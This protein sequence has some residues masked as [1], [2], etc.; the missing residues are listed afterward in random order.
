ME[1][2]GICIRGCTLI[3]LLICLMAGYCWAEENTTLTFTG[4]V[5]DEEGQAIE[6]VKVTFYDF[7]APDTD[8]MY[9]WA[10]LEQKEAMTKEDG[11]F[12]F[13]STAQESSSYRLGFIVAEKEGYAIGWANWR[14]R[15]GD[16]G[17]IELKKPMILGGKVIDESGIPVVDAEVGIIMLAENLREER[18][19]LGIEPLN[20]FKTMTDGEG[21]FSFENIPEGIM[22]EFMVRKNGKGTVSTLDIETIQQQRLNFQAGQDDIEIHIAD[23]S[24]IEGTVVRQDNKEP[25][26]GIELMLREEQGIPFLGSEAVTT[27]D[28]GTFR[29]EALAG[30]DYVL[31]TIPEQESEFVAKTLSVSIGDGERK[32]VI[33]ELSEGAELQVIV[34]ETE[35]GDAVENARVFVIN[36]ETG[37]S[38]QGQTD[39]NGIAKI[40]MPNGE[41]QINHI[42][43]EGFSSDRSQETFT[44]VS[45]ETKRIE[46]KLKGQPKITGVVTDE[47][48]NALEGVKLG[49]S[50][51]GQDTVSGYEGK[52]EVRWDPR[53][54]GQDTIYY[55]VARD[56]ERNLAASME[57]DEETRQVEIKLQDGVVF[58]G[59]VTNEKGENIEKA[60]MSV[61]MRAS[62][63]G[64]SIS[65]NE[66]Y[67]D[68]EGH[69]EIKAIP[70]GHRYDVSAGADGYGTSQKEVYSDDAIDNNL[71]VGQLTLPIAN[72]SVSGVVVDV[73]DEPMSNVRIYAYGGN[74][75]DNLDIRTDNE[76]KFVIE[77]VCAGRIQ[78]NANTDGPM[79]AY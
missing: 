79:Y 47:K 18:F 54:W 25:V 41:F 72:L 59:Q 32:S 35:Y 50:P 3:F 4:K 57:V 15:E 64:A 66:Y 76:G 75:P 37:Q 73:N 52:F 30:G 17:N 38:F 10:I 26:A 2:Y 40:R 43:K 19:L 74:Q 48:G 44:I 62:S 31:S 21:R 22:A 51:S 61:S 42:Y 8:R 60:R 69:F 13:D 33:L 45:G 9:T 68:K 1:R 23:E 53:H 27:G 71:D 7:G 36:P 28:D 16:E 67:T 39:E 12:S 5:V 34:T 46:M 78:L 29:F 58:K 55:L 11:A 70:V 20:L 65:Y 77:K 56:T 24:F 6:G 63:W 49:I 14:L